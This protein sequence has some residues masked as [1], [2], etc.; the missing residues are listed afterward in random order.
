[1]FFKID[2]KYIFTKIL[3]SRLVIIITTIVSVSIHFLAILQVK[4]NI[5]SDHNK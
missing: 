1:M 5:N 3:I 2:K 4:Y